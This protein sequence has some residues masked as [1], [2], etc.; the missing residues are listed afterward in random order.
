MACVRY[1]GVLLK[2]SAGP[3]T[4]VT[5]VMMLMHH[6]MR[7]DCN[8]PKRGNWRLRVLRVMNFELDTADALLASEVRAE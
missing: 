6:Y 4:D 8:V 2:M 3:W 1:V 7:C 5:T